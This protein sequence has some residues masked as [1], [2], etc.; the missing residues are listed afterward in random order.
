MLCAVAHHSPRGCARLQTMARIASDCAGCGDAG[1]RG[2]ADGAGAGGR[3]RR[4]VGARTAGG[5]IGALMPA[6]LPTSL[7]KHPANPPFQPSFKERCSGRVA[8]NPKSPVLRPQKP[9]P[10]MAY[11]R[12]SCN[13][14]RPRALLPPVRVVSQWP[15]SLLPRIWHLSLCL[16]AAAKQTRV[17]PCRRCGRSS[18]PGRRRSRWACRMISAATSSPRP[19]ARRWAH[20]RPCGPKC[21][22]ACN[23]MALIPSEQAELSRLTVRLTPAGAVAAVAAAAAA[24]LLV[25]APE[26]ER[27]GPAGRRAGGQLVRH[28]ICLVS[29]PLLGLR[30]C[31]C[32]AG[33]WRA[34]R[35]SRTQSRRCCRSLPFLDLP[36]PFCCPCT[37]FPSLPLAHHCL[38]L[39]LGLCWLRGGVGQTDRAVDRV[40]QTTLSAHLS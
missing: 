38:L 6:L 28:C 17:V 7:L 35:P 12:S 39:H 11:S 8:R 40:G 16:S 36:L 2:R 3:Q 37:V 23:T 33:S 4:V 21:G 14:Q 24:A 25:T 19:A 13:V 10:T 30:H 34:V 32:L 27:S 1:R 31:L 5:L 29:P 22:L 20:H 18:R 15:A 9:T 26:P